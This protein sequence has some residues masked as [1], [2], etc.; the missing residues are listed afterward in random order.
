[1]FHSYFVAR[2]PNYKD[3]SLVRVD[4]VVVTLGRT[5]FHWRGC[6]LACFGLRCV[7][8]LLAVKTWKC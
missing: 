6:K 5:L 8:V 7:S 4:N 2:L 1:M 3:P